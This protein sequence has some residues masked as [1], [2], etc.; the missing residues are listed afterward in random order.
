MP[1]PLIGDFRSAASNAPRAPE[2]APAPAVEVTDE[3]RAVT[4]GLIDAVAE[5]SADE[6]PKKELTPSEHY[7]ER[8]K[9]VGLDLY[10]ARSIVDTL[11]TQGYFEDSFVFAS[12]KG[13]FRSRS[14][15]DQLRVSRVLELENPATALAQSE[16]IIRCHLGASLV[17]WAGKKF[18]V[19]PDEAKM[20][21]KIDSLRSFPAPIINMLSNELSKFDSKMMVVFSDGAVDS[22]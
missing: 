5:K 3:D 15:A 21:E 16:I 10:G 22:F 13:V 11:I 1:A 8:L 17:E 14:Y 7:A 4:T 20:Q 6:T 18:Y 12:R 9:S 19:G 2:A